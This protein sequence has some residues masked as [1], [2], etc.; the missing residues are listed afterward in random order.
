MMARSVGSS[1]R[2]GFSVGTVTFRTSWW[3][4]GR[5]GVQ[6]SSCV[7]DSEPGGAPSQSRIGLS[8]RGM[9]SM[10]HLGRCGLRCVG[11]GTA[12]TALPC[13]DD[14]PAF[15]RCLPI[16]A[17][18]PQGTQNRSLQG[19]AIFTVETQGSP[20]HDGRVRDDTQPVRR[21]DRRACAREMGGPRQL[22]L[23]Y[24]STG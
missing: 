6:T 7:Q 23:G 20:Q 17:R 1:G 5:L 19:S 14:V 3:P 9:R 15:A 13:R 10:R 24:L 18:Y 22:C 2:K 8:T 12:P 21:I 16:R 4:P 11:I